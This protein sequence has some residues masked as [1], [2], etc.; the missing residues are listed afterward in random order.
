VEVPLRFQRKAWESRHYV[1]ASET[2]QAAPG[3]VMCEDVTVKPKLQWRS[4]DVG[5]F[6]EVGQL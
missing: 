2:S 3:R 1:S 5:E 6:R 4:Q